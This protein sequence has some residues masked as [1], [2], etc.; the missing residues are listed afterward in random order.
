MGGKKVMFCGNWALCWLY[1]PTGIDAAKTL[2]VEPVLTAKEM[3]DPEVDHIGIMAY[4]A[5]FNNFKPVRTAAEKVVLDTSPRNCYIGQ[6]VCKDM[7]ML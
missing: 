6:E 4:A 1:L 2:G 7:L 3:C 5:Y